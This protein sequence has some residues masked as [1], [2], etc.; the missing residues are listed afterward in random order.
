MSKSQEQH[1]Q[2]ELSA[3][4]VI[5]EQLTAITDDFMRKYEDEGARQFAKVAHS[6]TDNALEG[7][8]KARTADDFLLHEKRLSALLKSLK[9]KSDLPDNLDDSLANYRFYR[10]L[11]SLLGAVHTHNSERILA[12]QPQWFCDHPAHEEWQQRLT[13]LSHLKN[14][15]ELEITKGKLFE[16]VLKKD[17]GMDLANLASLAVIERQVRAFSKQRLSELKPNKRWKHFL[18][19]A[20]WMGLGLGLVITSSVLGLAFPFLAIPGIVLGAAVVGYSVIDFIKQSKEVYSELYPEDK[21]ALVTQE[22]IEN[23]EKEYGE[24]LPDVAFGALV[25]QQLADDKKWSL[26]KTLVIGLG[27]GSSATGLALAVAGMAFLFPGLGVPLAMIIAV[28]VAALAVISFSSVLLGFKAYRENAEYNARQ[29]EMKQSII[30][31][32]QLISEVSL[33]PVG[34]SEPSS[35]AK[36]FQKGI[37]QAVEEEPQPVLADGHQQNEPANQNSENEK[38]SE[39]VNVAGR[40]DDGESEGE[41]QRPH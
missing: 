29:S 10:Y 14:E 4:A 22:F 3:A 32:N 17:A 27:Y 16:E 41:K 12:R 19:D 24:S 20:A 40:E 6:S 38:D 26:E 13:Q 31:D 28:T 39:P 8:L 37:A 33:S 21:S 11:M 2:E 5:K 15:N 36:L 18:Q 30:E 35:T 9:K 1:L 7:M 23:L 34:K 25:K